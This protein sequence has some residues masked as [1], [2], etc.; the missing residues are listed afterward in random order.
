MLEVLED[1]VEYRKLME[2]V[3]PYPDLLSDLMLEKDKFCVNLPHRYTSYKSVSFC[4]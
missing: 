2:S 4:L 1:D 3:K